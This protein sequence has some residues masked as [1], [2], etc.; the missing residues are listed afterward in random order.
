LLLGLCRFG[1]L[2]FVGPSRGLVVAPAFGHPRRNPRINLIGDE[3]HG[4]I[5]RAAGLNGLWKMA[6]ARQPHHVFGVKSD[7][8]GSLDLGK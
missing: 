6:G 8:A 2:L 4:T 1:W 3:A 5:H 7:D